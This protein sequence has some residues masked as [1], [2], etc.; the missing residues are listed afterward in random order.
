MQSVKNK[1]QGSA[2]FSKQRQYSSN[3]TQKTKAKI[4]T[5]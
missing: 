4:E 1:K 2:N 5:T 3:K